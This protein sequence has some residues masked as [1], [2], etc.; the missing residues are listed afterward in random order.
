MRLSESL[1]EQLNSQAD[2]VGM[3]RKH[4]TLKPAGKEFKGC[5]PFHGEKTPS[6]YVNPE[7]NL[8]YC[9]GCQAKGNPITFL[10]EFERLDFM[11]AVKYLSDQTG[12]ELPKD[13]QQ[14]QKVRYKKTQPT[15]APPPNSIDDYG[16][17]PP[18]SYQEELPP[19]IIEPMVEQQ[20][21]LY[22]LLDNV[23]RYYQHMLHHSPLAK[24]YFLERGLNEETIQTF[25]LG[26]APED[27]NHLEKTFPADIEG[28]KILG[29]VR[30]SQKTGK[31]FDLLRH[32]V[33]FPIKDNRGRIVGFAGRSLG[34]ELPKYINSSESP[35]FQKQH[36]LYGFYEAR[37]AKASHYMMVEGYMDVI[38]LHQAGIYGAVAPMGTAANEGQIARLLRHHDS[39]TL[40]FD[41]DAAGQKAAWRTLE[42]AAPVLADGKELKFLT[43]PNNHDPD[44]YIRQHGRQAMQQHID[45][46]VSL[47]DY[48]YG[49]L[50]SRF[51][52]SRP[53]QKAAAMAQLRELTALLPKGSS[54]K[55]WLNN[56][57]YQKL[58]GNPTTKN[59]L[60]D[61]IAYDAPRIDATTQLCLCLLYYPEILNNNPLERILAE[62]GV[63]AAHQPYQNHLSNHQLA[64]PS[65]PTWHNIGN[66]TLA[67]LIQHIHL[68]WQTVAEFA[69]WS[70]DEQAHFILASLDDAN[71]R[72][73]LIKESTDYLASLR[74]HPLQDISLLVDELIC[75]MIKEFLQK[76]QADNKNLVLSEINKKR[77]HALMQWDSQKN[78]V[79][80][81]TL[82][83]N[84]G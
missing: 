57:I 24:R 51:D 53:E 13:D 6:F 31:T 55:W 44:T 30:D 78:K 75:T 74:Q 22:T 17:I 28:L 70:S 62:S 71:A 11:E 73:T 37:Q 14:Q 77:L 76:E 3:I 54:L 23:C 21:D 47:S 66:Q 79:Q 9:F 8:Y 38:A 18:S 67:Q 45:Q 65:L 61:A 2:L 12:I 7:T 83:G 56:D 49:V 20:G 59:P 69:Q 26:Y 16:Y 36:I 68:A 82:L 10:K 64:M 19:A 33:I 27:W 58:K 4:T 81:A 41:G 29:L 60:I 48:L 5:C 42:I 43:L 46:S 32:R 39:L 1:I 72:H 63:Q 50:M 40:C 25:H 84:L 34:D 15:I 52:L 35:V 80:I